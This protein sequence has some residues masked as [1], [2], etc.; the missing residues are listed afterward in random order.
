MWR[1]VRLAVDEA[2]LEVRAVEITRSGKSDAP[3]LRCLPLQLPAGRSIA[4]ITADGAYDGRACRNAIADQG[5]DTV[6]CHK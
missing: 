3:L 2:T 1:N 4:S 6:K 5:A